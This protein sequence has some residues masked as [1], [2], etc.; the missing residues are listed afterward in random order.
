MGKA[1]MISKLE[2]IKNDFVEV[3]LKEKGFINKEDIILLS[4][5]TQFIAWKLDEIKEKI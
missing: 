5:Y 4:R 2:R 3:I 1:S